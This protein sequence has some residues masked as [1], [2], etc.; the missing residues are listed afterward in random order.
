MTHNESGFRV[1]R[2]FLCR[3][4]KGILLAAFGST[5]PEAESAFENIEQMTKQ[6]F[7]DTHVRRAYTSGVV[8]KALDK[9]G[10]HHDSVPMALAR[11]ADEGFTHVDTIAGAEFHRLRSVV[12][13][14][15][16]MDGVFK[17]VRLGSPLLATPGEMKRVRDVLLK[18]LPE[19]RKSD[20]AVIWVGHETYHPS[21]AFY[22]ALAYELQQKD[23]NV[24]VATLGCLG[25]SPRF[26]D[27]REEI[28]EKKIDKA[29]VAPF[30]SVAGTH[31]VRDIAGIRDHESGNAHDHDNG[32]DHGHDHHHHH[33]DPWTKR[34]S[35]AGIETEMVLKGTGEYDKIV[36]IWLNRLEKAMEG[37]N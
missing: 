6:A 34:L 4:K 36:Q 3:V 37:L 1:I 12:E 10:Q 32:H 21:N 9:K 16:S 35:R 5:H 7:P 29:Y 28:L 11:M 18:S 25:G 26:E 24:F 33:K 20:E 8:R 19:G 27:V 2:L 14:F 22:P 31:A 17:R 13:G 23:E 15:D 30:M